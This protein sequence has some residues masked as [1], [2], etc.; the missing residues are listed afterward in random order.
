MITDSTLVQALR[1]LAAER[2]DYVYSNPDIENSPSACLYVHGDEPGCIVGAALH[3]LGV[4]LDVLSAYE[5]EG[6]S[7][8]LHYL[9]DDGVT[10]VSDDVRQRV[11]NVQRDQ[12]GREP[13]AKAVKALD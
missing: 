1:D 3:R 10:S 9:N 12:D 5:G 4:P 8:L 6:A 13:W 11:S 2:P 7:T